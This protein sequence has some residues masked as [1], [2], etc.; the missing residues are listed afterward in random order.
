MLGDTIRKHRTQGT[1]H[2]TVACGTN[3]ESRHYVKL[4][5]ETFENTITTRIYTTI[6]QTSVEVMML[7]FSKGIIN[8]LGYVNVGS[9]TGINIESEQEQTIFI[10]I[11]ASYYFHHVMRAI[12]I[13]H[14]HR[15]EQEFVFGFGSSNGEN[16][17][18]HIYHNVSDSAVR[19]RFFSIFS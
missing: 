6:F 4:I 15:Q 1:N 19:W 14:I 17:C 12:L 8:H 13:S 16:I 10:H 9:I 2:A 3:D 5:Q 7:Q 18:C 11:L